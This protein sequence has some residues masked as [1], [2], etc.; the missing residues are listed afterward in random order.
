MIISSFGGAGG[1]SS[2]QGMKRRTNLSDRIIT[3]CYHYSTLFPQALRPPYKR[4]YV[5]DNENSFFFILC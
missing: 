3:D 5:K 4:M 2:L 1:Y